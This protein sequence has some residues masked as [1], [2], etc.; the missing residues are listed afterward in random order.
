MKKYIFVTIGALLIMG[1]AATL[2]FAAT[3]I[4]IAASIDEVHQMNVV[5]TKVLN[6]VFTPV[7]D[8]T[9]VGM[10]FGTLVK[11]ADNVFRSDSFF[12]IDAPVISNRSGWSITHTRTN[13]ANAL[14]TDNLNSNTNVKFVKVDG[15]TNVETQLASGFVSYENSNAKIVSNTDVAN[16]WLRIY[17]SIAGGSADAP[18][19]N[20]I[21]TAKPIGT[22]T[23]T[24]TLTLSP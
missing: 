7:S 5:L 19:V 23:G 24:V 8:L 9:G 3:N 1:V 4:R 14:G 15:G 20:V 10:D 13:F 2:C 11:G 22:Y 12:F 17:Y 18:G 6:N 16:G 21:T